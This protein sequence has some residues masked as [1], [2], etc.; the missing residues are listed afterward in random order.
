MGHSCYQLR[1]DPGFIGDP[2][3]VA[4]AAPEN[5]AGRLAA[6]VGCV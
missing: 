1:H 6:E 5:G 3:E 2:S 4:V